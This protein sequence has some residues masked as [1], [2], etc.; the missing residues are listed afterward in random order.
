[1]AGSYVRSLWAWPGAI[2]AHAIEI[3]RDPLTDS[4][5]TLLTGAL[6]ASDGST[7]TLQPKL[8]NPGY[9]YEETALH[10]TLHVSCMAMHPTLLFITVSELDS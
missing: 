4:T 3:Y 10:H 1:M 2:A 6:D 5:A 9:Y 8:A 7:K